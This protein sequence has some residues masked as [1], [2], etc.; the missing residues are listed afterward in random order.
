[1]VGELWGCL[2]VDVAIELMSL[3]HKFFEEA[4]EAPKTLKKVHLSVHFQGIFTFG[5]PPLCPFCS[6][7]EPLRCFNVDSHVSNLM[8]FC[9]FFIC[10]LSGAFQSTN[11]YGSG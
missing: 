6:S 3:N 2:N 4:F 9:G 1:M 7:I 5:I 10:N 8:T 11:A